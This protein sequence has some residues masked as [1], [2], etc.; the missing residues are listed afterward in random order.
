MKRF[1]KMK[2]S[3]RTPDEQLAHENQHKGGPF[4]DS[5]DPD[6][7]WHCSLP[8][9]HKHFLHIGADGCGEFACWDDL[10]G[11]LEEAEEAAAKAVLKPMK[12]DKPSVAFDSYPRAPITAEEKRTI[13]ELSTIGQSNLCRL[14]NKETGY[15]CTRQEGHLGKHIATTTHT[16]CCKSWDEVPTIREEAS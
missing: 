16:I 2:R 3:E 13:K 8:P 4:C 12:E 6:G 9:G 5:E 15:I 1:T 7:G 10:E 14:R 11:L